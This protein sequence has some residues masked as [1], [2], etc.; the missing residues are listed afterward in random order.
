MA[1]PL[2]MI[3]LGFWVI[4]GWVEESVWR[5]LGWWGACAL[6]T[7]FVMLFAVYD[8]LAVIREEREKQRSDES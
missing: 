8:V 1:V 6:A 7:G 5:F 2:G 4:D 3:V